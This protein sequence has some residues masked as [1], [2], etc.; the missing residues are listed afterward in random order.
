ME[1]PTLESLTKEELIYYQEIFSIFDKEDTGCI[2]TS[3]FPTFVRGLGH[4][5]TENEIREMRAILDP[6]NEGVIPFA[7]IISLLLKRPKEQ[8]IEEELMEA[9]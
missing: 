9:F 1:T 6:S 7:T 5:P 8:N 2:P 3:H 4:C